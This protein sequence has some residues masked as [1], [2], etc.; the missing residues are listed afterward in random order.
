MSLLKRI[1]D[2]QDG[3][4]LAHSAT[5]IEAER[6]RNSLVME[7][8]SII[9]DSLQKLAESLGEEFKVI[10]T[11]YYYQIGDLVLLV[12]LFQSK[13]GELPDPT[14][15]RLVLMEYL[16]WIM[17][18]DMRSQRVDKLRMG[19]LS[20]LDYDKF[21]RTITEAPSYLELNATAVLALDEQLERFI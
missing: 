9:I 12:E 11:G 21:Y 10:K 2:D 4:L 19:T 17:G 18:V 15:G 16:V 20:Y 1:Q 6:A 7:L 5:Q 8:E 14:K 3:R 13:T